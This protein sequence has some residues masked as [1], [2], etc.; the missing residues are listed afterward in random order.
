MK[1]LQE[2]MMLS[3]LI[4]LSLIA[5]TV[6]PVLAQSLEFSVPEMRLRVYVQPDGSARMVY[7]ITFANSTFGDPIDIVDIGM[8]HGG[9]DIGNMSAR[10]G[11]AVLTDIRPSEFV[12][13]GV[14]IHLRQHAIQSGETATLH[15]EFTMP[16]MIYQDVTRQD[17]ASLQIATTW[18][19][20]QFVRGATDLGI[21]VYMLPDVQPEEMLYQ[22]EPFTAQAVDQGRTVALWRW[23]QARASEP[24]KVGVSFPKRGMTRVVEQSVF[25][26]AVKWLEDN[27]NVRLLFGA[28][29]IAGFAFL[30]FRFTG[31]TGVSLFVLLAGGLVV[32]LFRYP[33]AQLLVVLPL[34]ALILINEGALVRRRSRYLPAVAQVEGG[35]IKRGLTAPEAAVLLEMPLNKVLTLVIFGL[36]K[37]GVLQQVQA[38]PLIVEVA[39]GFEDGDPGK[40]SKSRPEVAQEKGI[41]L[42]PYEGP[43]IDA[44][45][46]RPGI[47]V[48]EIDFS[49]PMKKLVEHTATRIKGFDLS[50]TQDYYRG[51]IRRAL[52]QAQAIGDI[53][54]REKVLDRDMEWILLD[55]GFP[56]VFETRGY[57]YRPIWLRPASAIGRAASGGRG[58]PSSGR[59]SFGDVAGGFAGWAENTMGRLASAILPGS[60]QVP[61]AQGGV[62]NLGGVDKVT[63]D[64]FKAMATSSG[65][66][67]GGRSGGGCA[68]A[69]AGCACACACAGG[70][71]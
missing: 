31:G 20:S 1:R 30:Y 9:Y 71:R 40:R 57:S 59:T 44:L 14:E 52:K 56:T 68:C 42:H 2:L 3:A 28:A 46:G 43:F 22:L 17:Y 54:E 47:P 21:A 23:E 16:D 51:I 58:A 50:D 4:L 64:I 38:S 36:L 5:L 63:G 18:F 26:L 65:S 55:D 61:S 11:D 24:Y 7:D 60:L 12:D 70:G 6:V 29:T 10:I 34:I 41:V 45:E 39:G 48:H 8:P 66:S 67:G 19:D 33:A 69:C 27:P 53:P 35:G 62:I 25:D 32:L 37:K 13:P 15:F 49:Q